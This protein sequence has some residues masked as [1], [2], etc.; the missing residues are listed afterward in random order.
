MELLMSSVRNI[1]SKYPLVNVRSTID[2]KE[3][4]VRD[5]KDKQ[6]AANTLSNVR[7]KLVKLCDILKQKYPDK[8]QI[9]QMITNFSSDPSRYIEATPD[10]SH[11]SYSINKGESVHLCLRERNTHDESI[12]SDN[13][14]LFV[15]LHELSHIITKSIGHGPDFWN[16]FGWLL[17]EAER[18]GIYTYTNFRSHPVSYCGVTISD[19]PRYDPTK[20][21]TDFS[22]GKIK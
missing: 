3:Y 12:V 4:A 1:F 2:G 16:N 14:L 21:G 10:S 17:Q 19:S 6:D 8:P 7:I 11:T 20:D 15:A 13:V 22:I 5:M 9:K 18:E